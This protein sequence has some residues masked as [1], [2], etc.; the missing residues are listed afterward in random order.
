MD[1][2][3]DKYLLCQMCE[4]YIKRKYDQESVALLPWFPWSTCNQDTRQTLPSNDAHKNVGGIFSNQ[5][6]LILI[7]LWNNF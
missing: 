6:G 3:I 7:G 2:H 5:L 4:K 1:N